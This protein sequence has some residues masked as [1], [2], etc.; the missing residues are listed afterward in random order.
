[1]FSESLTTTTT[2]STT[3]TTAAFTTTTNTSMASRRFQ[4]DAAVANLTECF[5][6]GYGNHVDNRGIESSSSSIQC[7]WYSELME[8]YAFTYFHTYFHTY[9]QYIDVCFHL[10]VC[11][12]I[13][14]FIYT[15]TW[16]WMCM[17]VYM[18]SYF[19]LKFGCAIGVRWGFMGLLN[20]RLH[21]LRRC[22]HGPHQKPLRADIT[23]IRYGCVE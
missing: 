18:E 9:I 13:H 5:V 6:C 20:L 22:A 8:E 21:R 12:Y 16:L 11:T 10:Y 17:C 19:W 1:M 15:C 4:H 14:P 23:Y 3:I 7:S 2:T